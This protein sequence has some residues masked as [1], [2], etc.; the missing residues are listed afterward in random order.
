VNVFTILKVLADENRLR[1]MNILK[2]YSLCVG[3]IQTILNISQSNASRHLEK[4]KNSGLITCQKKKQW[5]Y[6]QLSNQRLEEYPFIKQL[7]F[8]D[9]KNDLIF[10]ED[11]Y[12]LNKYKSSG[13]CCQDL[14]N[15]GFD[16]NK[17][18]F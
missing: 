17:I 1:I 7:I 6:Y 12:K 9:I 11:L 16:F 18:K 5:I 10:R 2:E 14:K 8:E 15:I 3:E 4:L 13:L